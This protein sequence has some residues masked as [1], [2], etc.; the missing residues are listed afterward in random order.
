VKQEVLDLLV[1]QVQ[2]AQQVQ[3]ENKEVQV[4][5]DPLVKQVMSALQDPQALKEI[6]D[7]LDLQEILD[8][9]VKL[10]QQD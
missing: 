3:L 9:V 6:L 2:L 7:P 1:P 5:Q 8:L 4:K 10:A